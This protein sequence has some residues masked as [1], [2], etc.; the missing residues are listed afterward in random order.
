MNKQY[1]KECIEIL[2]KKE[3]TE[4]LFSFIDIVCDI[5]EKL[6]NIANKTHYSMT[7][8]LTLW[9][10]THNR[11]DK[12]NWNFDIIEVTVYLERHNP[13]V[14]RF[15]NLW[16]GKP[17][18]YELL[19]FLDNCHLGLRRDRKEAKQLIKEKLEKLIGAKINEG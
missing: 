19:S 16:K 9:I 3:T 10:D 2:R 14:L 7:G 12:P 5:E 18:E 6:N 1:I 13:T 15:R 8:E 11:K 4:K 17:F